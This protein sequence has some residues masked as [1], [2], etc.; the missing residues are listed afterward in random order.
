MWGLRHLRA[1]GLHGHMLVARLDPE[2]FG[3]RRTF[4][5][6]IRLRTGTIR[7]ALGS[8]TLDPALDLRSVMRVL[9]EGEQ[10]VAAID[11][12]SDQVAASL[13][14]ELAGDTAWMPR[15]L[16]RSA[17]EQRIPVTV[18]LT[19]IHLRSGRRTLQIHPL[20]VVDDV[21]RLA[22]MVFALLDAAIRRAP[23]DWHFWSE[24]ERVFRRGSPDG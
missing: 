19:G 1:A 11:V 22:G 7:K 18:F 9:R 17:V 2:Q 20:G 3:Q 6:Y 8:E 14:V 4:Y 10:L 23:A 21:Q 15:A 5:N 13:P 12:P 16:L 24:A